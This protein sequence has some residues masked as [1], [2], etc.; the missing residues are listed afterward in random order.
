MKSKHLFITLFLSLTLLFSAL[1]TLTAPPARADGPLAQNV[2]L[3][4][5]IGGETEAVF[6]QSDRAYIGEV[7]R[8]TILDVPNP[9]TSTVLGKSISLPSI[10]STATSTGLFK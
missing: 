8:L 3:M 6:V 7:P 5:Q 9:A 10:F 4:G 1:L 2:E